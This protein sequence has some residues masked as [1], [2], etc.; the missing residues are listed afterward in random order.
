[1]KTLTF[2]LARPLPALAAGTTIVGKVVGVH[3]EGTLTLRIEDETLK[4]KRL[5]LIRLN[6]A[7]PL[8]TAAS[9]HYSIWA[10]VSQPP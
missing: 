10:S 3:D 6:W 9:S 4:V 8:V 7:S 5:V 1:M 2:F